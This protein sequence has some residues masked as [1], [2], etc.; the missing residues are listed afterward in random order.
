VSQYAHVSVTSGTTRHNER[1]LRLSF[2]LV[3]CVRINRFVIALSGQTKAFQLWLALHLEPLIAALI[4]LLKHLIDD[5]KAFLLIVDRVKP[6][7]IC[8]AH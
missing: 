1:L 5:L 2:D 4:V 3:L 6:V 8:S 7:A